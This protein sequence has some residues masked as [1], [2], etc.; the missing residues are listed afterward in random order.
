MSW[1]DYWNQDTPIYS[2][3]R[4]KLLHYRLVSN[5]IIG[6]IP[7]ADAR[8]LDHGCGEALFADRVAR[9]CAHLY[10]CDGA[11]LVRDRLNQRFGGHKRLTILAPEQLDHIPDGSL[12]LI[13]VNS[14]LQYLS[15]EELRGLLPIWRDL[16]KPEGRLIL[17]DVIPH[18]VSPITDAKA[19]LSLAWQGGFL[20]S[21][22]LGLGRTAF[23][24][25]REIREEVG[26]SQYAEDEIEEILEDAGFTARRMVRNMGHNQARMTFEARPLAP[27][28]EDQ[29]TPSS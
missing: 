11:P 25:Y 16:L 27:P 9:H 18:D 2:G 21:A 14:L 3:E 28:P 20:K 7:S 26:L 15:L 23:S 29:P 12:D 24:E 19:L 6:L 8:V 10:L 22:L 5:D 4:H 17:A 13:V 1:R